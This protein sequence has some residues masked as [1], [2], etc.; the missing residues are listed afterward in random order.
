MWHLPQLSGWR[1]CSA[2]NECRLWQAEHE[3]SEPSG[4]IRPMPR[5]GPGGGIEFAAGSTLTSL[6]WHCQQPLTAAALF[7][8]GNAGVI[9]P[10]LPS[11][12][13]A[14]ALSSEPR[15]RAPFE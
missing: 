5:V 11:T 8:I 7:P 9:I 14:S 6:P 15:I 2:E 13:S 1:A 3:P 12:T 10:R 4:L